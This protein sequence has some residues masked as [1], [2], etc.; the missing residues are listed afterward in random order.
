MKESLGRQDNCEDKGACNLVPII[1]EIV[2]G[3]Y[4]PGKSVEQRVTSRPTY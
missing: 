2:A 1:Y 4:M 3:E